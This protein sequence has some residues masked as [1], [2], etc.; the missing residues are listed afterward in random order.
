MAVPFI[1]E[2]WV[3]LWPALALAGCSGGQQVDTNAPLP[4]AAGLSALQIAQN[5]Y[6]NGPRTPAN[7]YQDPPRDP[8]FFYAV[9]HLKNSHIDP[10]VAADPSRAEYE[11]CASDMTEAANMALAYRLA[12]APASQL[13]TS[14][15][16]SEYFE[17]EA[18]VPGS[19]QQRTVLRVFDCEF[20]DRDSVNLRAPNG[21]GGTIN[22]RPLAQD[23]V[24]FLAEYSFLFGPYNNVGYQVLSSEQQPVTDSLNQTLLIA[25]LVTAGSAQSCDQLTVFSLS[26]SADASSGAVRINELTEWTISVHL[27]DG[28]AQICQ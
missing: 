26:H 22:R 23:P 19:T 16:T 6:D 4:Q 18:D 7:F 8:Q 21:N 20:V 15:V 28:L 13:L 25:E 24:R 14:V 11:L 5:A 27:S 10:T 12:N 17:Y 2:R 9:T 3:M 1:R